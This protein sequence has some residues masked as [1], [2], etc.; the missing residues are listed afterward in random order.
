M[1][2][3]SRHACLLDVCRS[4][5]NQSSLLAIHG[6]CKYALSNACC[7]QPKWSVYSIPDGISVR[8]VIQRVSFCDPKKRECSKNQ[9]KLG[10]R[11]QNKSNFC[12]I[13]NRKVNIRF[14]HYRCWWIDCFVL[15][16]LV[17]FD[18]RIPEQN[19]VNRSFIIAVVTLESIKINCL[20]N[21]DS[22]WI[23][24]EIIVPDYRNWIVR[25]LAQNIPRQRFIILPY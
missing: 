5:L 15:T 22:Q 23:Q 20:I 6:A 14:G 19:T 25:L 12:Q 11:R 9:N 8:L 7:R 17:P 24:V 21:I 1:F 10:K 4:G 3:R 16:I 13:L 18:W 2:W